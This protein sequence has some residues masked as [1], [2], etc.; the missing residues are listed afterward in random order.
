MEVLNHSMINLWLNRTRLGL[1]PRPS[2][3]PY[4]L[5]W[6]PYPSPTKYLI[7]TNYSCLSPTVKEIFYRA[8]GVDLNHERIINKCEIHL[9]IFS[10]QNWDFNLNTIHNVYLVKCSIIQMR[11][12]SKTITCHYYVTTGLVERRASSSPLGGLCAT[13]GTP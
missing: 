11:F 6:S 9:M 2:W 7:F 10:S 3:P 12:K 5:P 1:R 8:L 4:T 13:S